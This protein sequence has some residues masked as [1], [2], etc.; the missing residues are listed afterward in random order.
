MSMIQ[1]NTNENEYLSVS[2]SCEL[3]STNENKLYTNEI[4]KV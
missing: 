1:G 2:R 3:H 4:S